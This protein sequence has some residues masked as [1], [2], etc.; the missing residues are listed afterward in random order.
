MF[1]T[2]Q[3]IAT[4]VQRKGDGYMIC[5]EC[6]CE[7]TD[8]QTICPVCGQRK[9]LGERCRQ[10]EREMFG[11]GLFR[12]IC[13]L[14]TVTAFLYLCSG[15]FGLFWILFSIAGWITCGRKV[16][17]KRQA[18]G[19]QFFCVTLK[20]LR[21][22][23]LILAGIFGVLPAAV[24]IAGIFTGDTWLCYLAGVSTEY[25]AGMMPVS[26]LG[27]MLNAV[28][29]LGGMLAV[30]IA[31]FMLA[32]VAA[33]VFLLAKLVQPLQGYM[34]SMLCAAVDRNAPCQQKIHADVSLI[35]MGA[36]QGIYALTYIGQ[37]IIGLLASL[38]ASAVLFMFAW[39]VRK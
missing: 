33:A 7:Y 6:G 20:I 11:S 30:C 37:N 9:D 22:V 14:M 27:R 5:P 18:A 3:W 38:C 21:I 12:C 31:V 23:M 24:L 25:G 2:E 32:A 29:P 15:R 19:I 35:V 17:P 28:L 36:V 13:I 4:V 8:E 16:L 1:C 26:Q 39:L 34:E 10:H